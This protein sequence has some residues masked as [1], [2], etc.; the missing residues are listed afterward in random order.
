MTLLGAVSTFI[1]TFATHARVGLL[2]NM[3]F[4][5]SESDDD[6]EPGLAASRKR[7]ATVA[8]DASKRSRT[9]LPTMPSGRM[10]QPPSQ[11]LSGA[12]RRAA[13]PLPTTSHP[14]SASQ[15]SLSR[16]SQPRQT[17]P[18]ELIRSVT[19][20]ASASAVGAPVRLP[21]QPRLPGPAELHRSAA[22]AASA[23]A[24]A[25]VRLG[26]SAPY[27]GDPS[28]VR[29]PEP[30]SSTEADP[31]AAF[32]ML[33]RAPE[34]H[35]GARSAVE[36]R[37][38]GFHSTQPRGSAGGGNGSGGGSG[39]GGG[40]SASG[41][42]G[43]SGYGGGPPP[44]HQ[45]VDLKQALLDHVLSWRSELAETNPRHSPVPQGAAAESSSGAAGGAAGAAMSP[46]TT[47]GS[48]N[49]YLEHFRPLLLLELQQELLKGSQERRAEPTTSAR[50]CAYG[51]APARVR[52]SPGRSGGPPD[53]W[54]SF[55]VVV[56]VESADCM[57][58]ASLR[59][60]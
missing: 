15:H 22:P 20:P 58:I 33:K 37:P 38:S 7:P 53:G 47:F 12:V 11:E 59:A 25:P 42:G 32:E 10:H 27:P 17:G 46:P 28:R 18:A 51:G 50:F 4:S 13:P 56:E 52:A 39:G 35:G 36:A 54:A 57:L 48:A 34:H 24:R 40:G 14:F 45:H 21:T 41:G 60:C 49:A 44:H 3:P 26:V 23:S 55:E 1:H 9:A 29:R 16:P 31:F 5:F 8:A 30:A 43:A 6:D 19:P 2:V